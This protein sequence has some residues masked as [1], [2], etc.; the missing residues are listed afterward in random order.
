MVVIADRGH[1]VCA[2]CGE[3]FARRESLVALDPDDTRITSLAREPEI[4]A[5]DFELLHRQC[6]LNRGPPPSVDLLP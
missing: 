6:F 2:H 5:A 3:R 1:V 4:E